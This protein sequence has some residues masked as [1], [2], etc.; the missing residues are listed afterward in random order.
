MSYFFEVVKY[1]RNLPGKILMQDK[2]GWR[3]NT[4]LHWHKELEFVYMIQGCLHAKIDGREVK[5]TP[6]NFYFCNSEEIHITK[7]E[8]NVSNYKYIVVLLS[9]EYLK[10]YCE[11]IDNYIF[12][13]NH[14]VQ[15][16]EELK[17]QF[18]HLI[19]LSTLKDNYVSLEQHRT[20]LKIY[21]ILLT[22]C[23]SKREHGFL[24]TITHNLIY[25]KQIIQY[26]DENYKEKITL[27]DMAHKIGL[28]PQYLS[29]YF[30][31]ITGSS[32]VQYVSRI[33]L[34]HANQDILNKNDSVTMAALDNG[35]SSVK[36]YIS[37]CKKIY[38]M[39][40]KQYKSKYFELKD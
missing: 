19:T 30:R 2:P 31:N 7:A 13:V 23:I 1:D 32:F 25:A 28:S 38:G 11:E 35:F 8:D 20:I 22:Q 6:G 27:Q 39:T 10:Q 26:I 15:V 9:Y 33:R 18:E 24:P 12:D 16:Q 37:T 29:K 36:S 5:L 40:P 4:I 21:Y 14:N 3:C 17:R 34:E